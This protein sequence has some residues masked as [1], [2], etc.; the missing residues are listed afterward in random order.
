MLERTV[1]GQ[2]LQCLL[3]RITGER[4]VLARDAVL[5][6]MF[7]DVPFEGLL[8]VHLVHDTAI[9]QE[10][11]TRVNRTVLMNT[12]FNLYQELTA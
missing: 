6:D 7:L 1:A 12:L 8:D 10:I 3:K 9:T 5:G 11:G 2:A 4:F